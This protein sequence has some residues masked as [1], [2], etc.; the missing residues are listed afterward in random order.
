MPLFCRISGPFPL[1]GLPIL[2]VTLRLGAGIIITALACASSPAQQKANIEGRVVTDQGVAVKSATVRLETDDGELVADQPV[3]TAGEFYF[4]FI[5]KKNYQLIVR[6]EGF[7]EYKDRLDLGEGAT[8]YTVTVNLTPLGKGPAAKQP[9]SLTDTTAS[10][11]ARRQYQKAARALAR[12]KLGDARKH[13]EAAVSA[14]PCYAR[15]QTD[16]A[17]VLTEQRDFK[18]AEEAL[19][20]S[21]SC[22]PGY[23]D[24][25]L[26]FGGLLNA[27]KRFAEADTILEQG[28]RQSPAAWQFYYQIGIAQYGLRNYGAAELELT[29]AQS[30]APSPPGELKVKLADVYLKENAFPKAYAAMADY[31]K[32][33][34]DGRLAPRVKEIMKQMQASG[35]LKSESSPPSFAPESH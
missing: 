32:M 18:Q 3:S 6:A 1:D 25:D 30:L 13:L 33:E 2:R 7:Q 9:P 20:K 22:D 29:K 19:K 21:I 10:S 35:V 11:D 5:P 31:L 26:E 27:E 8:D 12:H 23:I 15:A 14:Y 34:P 28:V 16:L 24:A 4:R 17:M